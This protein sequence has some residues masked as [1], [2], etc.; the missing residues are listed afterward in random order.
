MTHIDNRRFV[1]RSRPV[2]RPIEETWTPR[3][4]PCQIIDKN[5]APCIQP[6]LREGPRGG[7]DR[8]VIR[9]GLEFT[10]GPPN[11]VGPTN[12]HSGYPCE[13]QTFRQNR[14]VSKSYISFLT[15]ETIISALL[16]T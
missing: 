14:S 12:L 8:M 16:T 6:R 13:V 11:P 7:D 5:Q 3:R 10:L 9:E 15:S 4:P 1:N 2:P